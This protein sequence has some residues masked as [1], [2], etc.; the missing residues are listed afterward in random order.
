M[1]RQGELMITKVKSINNPFSWQSK[2]GYLR[3]LIKG[4]QK[5]LVL[6]EGELTGHLHE[7]DLGTLYKGYEDIFFKVP[8]TKVAT[9]TH[10]EHKSLT[11]TEGIYKVITQREYTEKG[12]MRVRD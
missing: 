9:L 3:E 4:K 12:I 2:I 8:K 1:K 10:P 5:R 6:A 7:L 11:F